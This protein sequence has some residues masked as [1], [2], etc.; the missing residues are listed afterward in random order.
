VLGFQGAVRTYQYVKASQISNS[1]QTIL[2]T[3]WA[4]NAMRFNYD[5]GSTFQVWSHRPISGFVA[6]NGSLDF[7]GL[8]PEAGFRR[9]TAADLDPDPDTLTSPPPV[10]LDYVGRNH[11]QRIGYPDRRLSNFLYVDGHVE[12]KTVYDTLNPFQWGSEFWSLN[13]HNDLQNP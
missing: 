3:E 11:G 8:A 9:A 5:G 6:S 4:P 10:C 7:Y 13:P 1:S 2:A 12:T